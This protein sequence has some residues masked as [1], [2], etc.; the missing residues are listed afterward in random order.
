MSNNLVPSIEGPTL[1]DL[2]HDPNRLLTQQEI[3][4]LLGKSEAWAERHRW[5]KTGPSYF[6]VGRRIL[7]QASDVLAW[8][9]RRRVETTDQAA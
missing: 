6:R 5:A 7:Y 4:A 9:D 2:K 8:L 1:A 3:C